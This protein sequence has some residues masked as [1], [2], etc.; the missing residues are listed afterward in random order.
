[1]SRNHLVI[2]VKTHQFFPYA[3]HEYIIISARMICAA[4]RSCKKRV[5]SEDGFSGLLQKT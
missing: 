1:M 4:D 2:T 3:L 5:T